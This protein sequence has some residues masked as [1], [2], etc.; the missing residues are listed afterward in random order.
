MERL[1]SHDQL[2]ARSGNDPWVRWAVAADLPGEV[3]VHDEIALVERRG[4]RRGFWVAPLH[5]AVGR[6]RQATEAERVRG[7]LEELR[8]GGHLTR[9]ASQSISV[10]REHAAVAHEVFELGEGGDWDWLW[11][12]HEPRRR[13]LER[14][15][16]VLD[17]TADAEEITAFSIAHN[18]RVWA[19]TG[20]GRMVHWVGIRTP[21]AGLIAV[22]G[23]ELEATGAPHLAGIVTHT[24]HRGQ[25]LGT[26]VTTGLTRWAL[27]RSGV[28]TL[29]MYADNA[30]AR[31]VYERL[32]FRT[33]RAWHSRG[34]LTG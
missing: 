5:G 24:E 7:A 12:T 34:L 13:V 19:D 29:G 31:G 25:G 4:W 2:L 27:A 8:D 23:A 18:P 26:A 15:L 22:G 10:V 11:T 32:G 1:T 14:E 16:E 30:V 20:S 6:G 21:D 17:D 28:C 9:L 3:W 33:A